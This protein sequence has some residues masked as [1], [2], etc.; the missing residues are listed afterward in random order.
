MTESH[1]DV[2]GLNQQSVVLTDILLLQS[3]FRLVL[4]LIVVTN[5][6]SSS[7][8]SPHAPIGLILKCVSLLL[9]FKAYLLFLTVLSPRP[10]I[11][12]SHYQQSPLR[13]ASASATLR[14]RFNNK[15]E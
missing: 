12:H 1:Q 9:C 8:Y 14:Y 5:I 15:R 7:F 2:R 13:F 11:Y 4:P 3:V 6:L 10:E